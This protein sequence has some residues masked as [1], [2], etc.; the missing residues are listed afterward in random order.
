M[1]TIVYPILNSKEYIFL[2]SDE[3]KIPEAAKETA[4]LIL[5][6]D[7]LFDS[8]NGSC[9]QALAHKKRAKKYRTAVTPRSAHWALWNSSLPILKS[10]TFCKGDKSGVVPS[11]QSWVKTIEG[12]KLICAYLHS[13]GLYSLLLRNFNKDALKFF[14][15]GIRAHGHANIMPDTTAFIAAYKTILVNNLTSSHLVGRICEKDKGYNLKNIKLFL[16]E[17]APY[18]GDNICEIHEEH[19]II[20]FNTETILTGHSRKNIEKSGSRVLQW[21]DSYKSQSKNI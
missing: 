20:E 14:F 1:F 13:K 8:V 2:F 19:L 17:K 21:M 7:N 12:F 3:G 10:I 9:S 4:D 6:F 5:F 16:K 11:L 15:G 18:E